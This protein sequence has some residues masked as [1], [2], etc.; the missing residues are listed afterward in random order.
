MTRFQVVAIMVCM[1]INM[2][3][4]FDVL[5]IAFT[6]PS[7]S[8]EWGLS[9]TSVGVLLSSGLLGMVIGSLVLGPMADRFGRR[10]LILTCLVVITVGM[11]LSAL[12]QGLNQL[13]AMRFLTGLGIGG[14]LPG[15]NTIV[16][17]YSSLRWR[18]FWVSFLQTGYPI[19]ATVGGTLS[20]V[21][22]A[23]YGW[24]SAF[25]LGAAA[26]LIMIPIVWRQL[27]ESLDY[28]LAR[29]P[30]GA[31]KNINQVLEK[32]GRAPVEALPD[33]QESGSSGKT[34]YADLLATP[35]LRNRTL[36]LCAAFLMTM[37]SF[38][39]AMSWTPKILVDSGMST[40]QGISG[41]II[42]NAGGVIGCLVLGY[43]SS[44]MPL[45]R[46]IATYAVM[47]VLLMIV[48]SQTGT[49]VSMM[50]VVATCLG[51]F[52]FGSMVGLYA[53]AP[54][55][56]PPQSRAAGVSIAIGFGRIGG[57]AS[58]MLAGMLFDSGW[59][60]S[61]GYILFALPLVIMAGVIIVLGGMMRRSV[62]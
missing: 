30:S 44:R 42:L 29:R 37:V 1:V 61:D 21:L 8:A 22:I 19:G 13:A 45:P 4:G 7:I 12:S 6:A 57:V 36:L 20:A 59:A 31:L 10:I 58:P 25:Y 23:E 3:D 9:S 56:Y 62:H 52:L 43:L 34:G 40:S 47:T 49:A 17:E 54:Q 48:F 60:K 50:V 51:F 46:L 14:I 15:L 27:P 55:L 11:L 16:A 41:G 53:L 18:S 5:V 32:L 38:Y 26:S 28:L 33:R 39:F 24:R 35:A 2:M